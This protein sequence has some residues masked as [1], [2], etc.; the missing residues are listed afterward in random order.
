V[1][2]GAIGICCATLGEAEVMVDAGIPGV[3]ITSP[4]V[5]PPKIVRL[6]ALNLR[7]HHGLSV[8]VD[9]PENLA[10]LERAALVAS[11]RTK[12]NC[13]ARVGSPGSFTQMSERLSLVAL[14]SRAD[15]RSVRC[16]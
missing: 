5:T 6:I 3:H 14:I 4:Q 12:R 2:A 8:V 13:K 15:L 9:Y 16:S 7:A 10:A 11:Y 1:D